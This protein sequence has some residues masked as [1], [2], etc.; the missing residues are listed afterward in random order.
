MD[1]IKITRL[2]IT[3]YRGIEHI[4]I[5]IEPGGAVIKGPNATGKTSVLRAIRAAL[6]AQDIGPDA[7][8]LGADRS[9]ILIDLNVASVK[10]LI[11]KED[12]SVEVRSDG[13]SVKAPA[14]WLKELIGAAP[15]DPIEWYKLPADKRRA[16][17]LAAIP[18]ELP[19]AHA[20]DVIEKAAA[21]AGV[22]SHREAVGLAEKGGH[23][24]TACAAIAKVLFDAR[25]EVNRAL[26]QAEAEAERVL[27]EGPVPAPVKDDL[28]AKVAETLDHV[29]D[30]EG[31]ARRASEVETAR[32]STIAKIAKLREDAKVAL[33]PPLPR[34]LD[35]DGDEPPTP[36]QIRAALEDE[37]AGGK[38]GI[39]L[40]AAA[41]KE[42]DE[43]V[44]E[45]ID[46]LRKA[47]ADQKGAEDY[48]KR[49]EEKRLAA[50]RALERHDVEQA[51][52]AREAVHKAERA[53]EWIAQADALQETIGLTEEAPAAATIEQAREHHRRADLAHKAEVAQA[54]RRKALADAEAVAKTGRARAEVLT[55]AIDEFR[56]R[57]PRS[58]VAKASGI[59]GLSLEGERIVLDGVDIDSCSGAEQLTFAVD[60]ARRAN[61]RSKILVVDGLETLDPAMHQTFI[62]HATRGGYQ[63]IATRVDAGDN[64]FEAITADGGE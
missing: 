47:Q 43:R 12:S 26:H 29:R 27:E 35:P 14:K 25:T 18:I 11:G 50:S 55:A 62:H 19:K 53:K 52:I 59:E 46:R 20:L 7:I 24:L 44:A 58:L 23:A 41:K 1:G 64:V 51:T 30:L 40:A 28:A 6:A 60:L 8:R 37:Y 33:T 9:E 3:N 10:R 48:H 13:R 42:A 34:T 2:R 16:S 32:S 49:S 36:D 61:A 22:Y 54:A 38:K 4:D 57:I 39:E 63:L 56:D 45:L 31:R 21:A 5:P 17:L 15:L